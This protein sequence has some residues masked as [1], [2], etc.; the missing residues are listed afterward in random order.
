MLSTRLMSVTVDEFAHLPAGYIYWENGNFAVY[1]RNPPLIKMWAALP[2]LRSGLDKEF[3]RHGDLWAAG[4]EFMYRNETDYHA[5]FM[6]SRLMIALLGVGLGALVFRWSRE[7]FG[8]AG[9]LVSLALYAFS[10]NVIAHAGL[11]TTD[12]GAAAMYALVC[13]TLFKLDEKW[14][15]WRLL[16]VGVALG[17]AIITKFSCLAL[18]PPV[19]VLSGFAKRHRPRLGRRKALGRVAVTLAV[20]VLVPLFIINAGYG[21]SGSFKKWRSYKDTGDPLDSLASSPIGELPAPF[22]QKFLAGLIEQREASVMPQPQFLFGEV[23]HTGWWYYFVIAFLLKTPISILVLVV[24][25]AAVAVWRLDRRACLF[26]LVPAAFFFAV[27]SLGTRVNTGLR[28][29]LPIFPLLFVLVG[30]LMRKDSP[31]WLSRPACLFGLGLLIAWHVLGSAATFP[32]YLAYFNEFAGGQGERHLLDSN[33]D[34]GQD[35]ITLRRFMR[36]EGIERVHLATLGRVDPAVYGV[37]YEA[38]RPHTP[39]T[40]HVVISVNLYHGHSY[41]TPNNGAAPI[42]V[43]KDAYAWLREHEPLRRIGGSLYHFEID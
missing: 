26:L 13:Y 39:V 35:H 15:V 33:C 1:H 18:L 22:P 19:L 2:L 7:L 21:F 28:Y 16:F 27:F 40:G 36:Q 14:S 6:R 42:R 24:C 8:L 12:L 43:P 38:L 10:P 5:L 30:A 41:V 3:T 34:W 23:S 11:V 32:H 31:R 17:L 29:L 37:E 20:I 4:T 25:A 9:G